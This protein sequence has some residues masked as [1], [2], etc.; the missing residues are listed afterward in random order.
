MPQKKTWK[1]VISSISKAFIFKNDRKKGKTFCS[2]TSEKK[3]KGGVHKKNAYKCVICSSYKHL[4]LKHIFS[5]KNWIFIYGHQ[6]IILILLYEL[7]TFY[8]RKQKLP[9]KTDF[10][11]GLQTYQ[12]QHF[13]L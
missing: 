2:A 7:K 1:V 8:S 13:Q 11:A 4:K 6:I 9:L 10:L 12:E 3:K 5:Y